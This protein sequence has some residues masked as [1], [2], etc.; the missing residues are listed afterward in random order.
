MERPLYTQC[1]AYT[2][3]VCNAYIKIIVERLALMWKPSSTELL[4]L[5]I[6]TDCA[7]FRDKFNSLQESIAKISVMDE[8]LAGM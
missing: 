2:L 7:V 6:P 1:H 3:L 5:T 4:E 8:L